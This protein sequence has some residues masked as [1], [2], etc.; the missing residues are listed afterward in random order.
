M[1]IKKIK[2]INWDELT[3]RY[4]EDYVCVEN[5]YKLYIN[6]KFIG[7]ITAS[8]NNLK[9]L[10]VGHVISEGYLKPES[11]K[12]IHIDNNKITVIT[13]ELGI[14]LINNAKSG[15]NIKI[16]LKTIFKIMKYMSNIRG[17]WNITGGT[18][19]ACLFD[20]NGNEI[21]TIEDI[22]R[23][24]AVDKVIGYGILNNINLDDKIL[25]SSG[26]QPYGMVKK[27]I[28]AKIPAIISKSPST[29]KGI[30]LAKDNDIIL[31]G[32]ARKNRFVVYNGFERIIDKD[33]INKNE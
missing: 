7:N 11:I 20:L 17:I 30:E 9:E 16:P 24:N 14:K 31:I 3:S 5:H 1:T 18:H 27:V 2:I 8:P 13:D 15:N 4:G 28:N 32:F 29:D 22:G 12:D 6:N 23:H 25:V 19:W 10:G 26:R 21:I 33:K